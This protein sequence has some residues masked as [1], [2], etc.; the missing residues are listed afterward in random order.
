MLSI[1]N[2]SLRL[3]ILKD[4]L[5]WY[6]QRIISHLFI[7]DINFNEAIEILDEDFLDKDYIINIIFRSEGDFENIMLK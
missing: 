4:H 6:A 2:K 1:K 5:S 7:S 3:I